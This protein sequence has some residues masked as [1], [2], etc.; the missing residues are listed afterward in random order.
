MENIKLQSI[1]TIILRSRLVQNATIASIPEFIGS[2]FVSDY[3][4]CMKM[5]RFV[6][7]YLVQLLC[8][9]S[10]VLLVYKKCKKS[11]KYSLV[12][13]YCCIVCLISNKKLFLF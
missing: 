9:E 7:I 10:V 2:K 12:V 13:L 5:Q 8:L 4:S 3:L 6:Q 1:Y 11:V